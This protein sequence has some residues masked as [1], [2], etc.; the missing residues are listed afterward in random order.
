MTKP[1]DL[2]G[3][4]FSKLTVIERAENSKSGKTRWLCECDCGGKTVV[5]SGNLKS[6]AVK[7]CGCLKKIPHNKK[8]NE[9]HTPLYHKW[10]S[11][12]YRCEKPNHVAYKNY[13]QR[14]ITV[15]DEWH[16]FSAF[17]KWVEKTK[18]SDDYSVDR[19]DNNKG[20]S[21]E[22]CRWVSRKEQANNRRNN[23]KIEYQGEIHNLTE[24]SEL[25]RFDYKTVHNR[26]HKLGWSFEKAIMTPIDVKKSSKVERNDNG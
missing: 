19:I 11:M 15:C 22:N 18:I 6:G 8:H 20:Y 7:S 24:W 21:P 2:T 9:S 5:S 17:K 10:I 23:V 4:K 16:D 3:Q 14:G 1:I 25:L 13:G 26:M 12:I